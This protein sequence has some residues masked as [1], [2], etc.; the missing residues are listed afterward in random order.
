M[1]LVLDD[2]ALRGTNL[3][4]EVLRL[5][6]AIALYRDDK[7]TLGQASRLAEL[8]RIAFQRELG[9]RGT[10]MNYDEEEFLKDIESLKKL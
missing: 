8:P 6:L 5:E 1:N 4:K 2:Q 7:L 10:A 3:S 9:L